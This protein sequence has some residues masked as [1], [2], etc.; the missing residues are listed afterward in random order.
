VNALAKTTL[1]QIDGEI[2]VPGLPYS[3]RAAA[4]QTIF[5]GWIGTDGEVEQMRKELA[6]W[7]AVYSKDSRAAA[8]YEGF[9]RSMSSGPRR[10]EAVT[11]TE[12]EAWITTDSSMLKAP[13]KPWGSTHTRAFRHPLLREFDLGPVER[14]GGAGTVEADGATYREILDVSDWDRSQAVNVP[15][16]SGQPGSPYYDNL[17]KMWA[18]NQY[19]ALAFSPKAIASA[20]AHRLVLRP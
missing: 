6:D 10:G 20:A 11:A 15:G 5:R 19:F 17:Q 12:A 9:R 8:I 18:D 13:W 2:K 4:D 16:Q 7:D 14:S 3:L 1:A